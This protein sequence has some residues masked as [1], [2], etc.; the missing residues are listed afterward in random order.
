MTIGGVA[1]TVKV[2]PWEVDIALAADVSVELCKGSILNDKWII[3][4]AACLKGRVASD[5]RVNVGKNLNI[6]VR[7]TESLW[8]LDA[9]YTDFSC[10]SLSAL[11]PK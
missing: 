5:L 2:L 9:C 3:T 1:K 4:S 10:R 11:W 6:G 7:S 8:L